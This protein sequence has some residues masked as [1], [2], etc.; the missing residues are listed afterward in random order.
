MMKIKLSLGK[1]TIRSIEFQVTT[2][3]SNLH[4]GTI[5]IRNI[6][7][8]RTDIGNY[9]WI[10]YRTS[11]DQNLTLSRNFALQRI[12]DLC[13]VWLDSPTNQINQIT[14]TDAA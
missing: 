10:T 14:S 13:D 3:L 11:R 9:V 2:I 4:D 8:H 1:K 12:G 6:R 5:E 7:P